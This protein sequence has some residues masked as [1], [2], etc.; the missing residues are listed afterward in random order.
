MI[1]RVIAVGVDGKAV[2]G[3]PGFAVLVTQVTGTAQLAFNLTFPGQNIEDLVV[4]AGRVIPAR[5]EGQAVLFSDMAAGDE[6][7]ISVAQTP[8]EALV[9]K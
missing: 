5:F 4:P 3:G 1:S 9:L 8:E 7:V 6:L 2:V